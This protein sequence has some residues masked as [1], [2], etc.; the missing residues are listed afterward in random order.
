MSDQQGSG[1]CRDSAA[2]I[3]AHETTIS[4]LRRRLDLSDLD[5]RQTSVR[6]AAAMVQIG[7]LQAELRG[8]PVGVTGLPAVI[9]QAQQRWWPWRR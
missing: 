4:D 2:L 7:V 6:L 5:R 9:P 3:Q 1:K 8:V